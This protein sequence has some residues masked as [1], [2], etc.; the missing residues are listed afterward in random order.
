[1]AFIQLLKKRL[2]LT[3][4]VAGGKSLYT[5]L[6][7][8]TQWVLYV[9]SYS[10]PGNLPTGGNCTCMFFAAPLAIGWCSS[11]CREHGAYSQW[12]IS[13]N[14]EWIM[15]FSGKQIELKAVACKVHQTRVL[16]VFTQTWYSHTYKQ[17]IHAHKISL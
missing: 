12:N 15:T 6:E 10:T 1:M 7:T 5:V 14:H 16:S 8:R 13:H 3:A 9:P 17:N 2:L 4:E 11:L